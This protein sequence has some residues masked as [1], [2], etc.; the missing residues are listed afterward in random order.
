MRVNTFTKYASFL[1]LLFFSFSAILA[2][3]DEN[4]VAKVA[5]RGRVVDQNKAVIVGA[6]VTIK[7]ATGGAAMTVTADDSGEF[8]VQIDRGDYDVTVKADGFA[9]QTARISIKAYETRWLEVALQLLPNTVT[10]EVTSPGEYQPSFTSSGTKTPTALRD[11]PQSINVI[12]ARQISDQGLTNIGDT[13]RYSPG[14]MVHQGE[15]NRD[16]V[17]IRGQSSSADF[18]LNGVRDDVQYYRDLYNLDAVE[19][20][21]GPNALVFGRGGGGGIVNRVT[22]EAVFA[23]IYAFTAQG[24]SF[25]NA[26]GT[27]DVNTTLNSKLAFRVNGLAERADS[28]RDLFGRSFVRRV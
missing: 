10:V 21:R 22:K 26:R 5:I 27:F 12:D 13:L 25:G 14:V 6:A 11:I 2:F 16:Q 8:G 3:N 7:A 17:I 28:F 19:V 9:E 15:N 1:F 20:V 4:G 24:G 23:P 18:Y